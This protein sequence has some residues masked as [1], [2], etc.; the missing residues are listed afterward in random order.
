MKIAFVHLGVM[1]F[2]IAGHLAKADHAVT[3]RNRVPEK[4]RR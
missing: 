2:Q 4:A 1:G 3:V